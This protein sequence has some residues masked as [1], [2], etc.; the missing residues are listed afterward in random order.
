[1]LS[2][3][4]TE[5]FE[6]DEEVSA[7]LE[8]FELGEGIRLDVGVTDVLGKSRSFVQGLIA[9]ECVKVNGSPKKANYKVR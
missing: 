3:S 8:I 9:Q 5:D 2:E 7:E 4:V 6:I 1:M